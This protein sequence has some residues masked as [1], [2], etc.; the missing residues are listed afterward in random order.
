ME[1]IRDTPEGGQGEVSP[2]HED[3]T[4]AGVS[5][6]TGEHPHSRMEQRL[7]LAGIRFCIEGKSNQAVL[8]SR[9][10]YV[11]YCAI[12]R[13]GKEC[14]YIHTHTCTHTHVHICSQTR[15]GRPP[16]CWG[17]A[18]LKTALLRGSLPME[19]HV[20]GV[21]CPQSPFGPLGSSSSS[22]RARLTFPGHLPLS[23][24]APPAAPPPSR[25]VPRLF[26]CG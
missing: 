23:G 14:V 16:L 13:D 25:R 7:G 5:G 11:Q 1:R 3:P 20:L 19:T 26:C 8:Y 24:E 2:K 17:P 15:L 6:S 12:N 9:E 22:R 10:N 4:R 21:L 18:P